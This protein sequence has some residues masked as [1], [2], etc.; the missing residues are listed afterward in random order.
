M[1]HVNHSPTQATTIPP[2]SRGKG[3]GKNDK[4]GLGGPVK[5]GFV[6]IALF[7]GVFGGW[8]ALAP[9]DSAA[10][11]PGV[12]RVDTNRKTVQHLEGGIIKDI[13]VRDGDTVTMGQILI[14]LDDTQA[15]ATLDLLRGRK[16]AA[17]ALEARLVAERDGTR[18]IEFP[19]WLLDDDDPAKADVIAGQTKIFEARRKSLDTQAAILKQ[20]IAQ[21]SE[22]IV[23]LKG[24]IGSENKQLALILEEI[25]DVQTLFDKG[26]AEKPR[27]LAL[28]RLA[29]EIEGN[30]SQNEANIARIKQ[31]IG[32]TRLQI[33]ELKAAMIGEVVEQHREVQSE[34]F[35]LEERM[36]A[37]QDIL[38]RTVIRAPL[39]GTVVALQVYTR[40]GVIS[41][42]A[43]ILDIVPSQDRLVISAQIDPNDIDVV[44][45]GQKAEVRFTAFS[46]RD[47]VPV[48]GIVASVSADR[49]TD[50]TSGKSYFLA[51][52]SLP[53]E[54]LEA[55]ND[56]E[57]V[58][59]MQAE[60]M[61]IT[62]E[63]TLLDY[64]LNPLS[65]SIDRSLRED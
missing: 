41:P 49:L 46:R 24:Q 21:F 36:L 56:A 28:Q 5:A 43:P 12:V 47:T 51:R 23:G 65:R 3:P 54:A 11:A 16:M 7:F 14:E 55:L 13:K 53:D 39:D 57:L 2:P 25:G 26:L 35:D 30:R 63:R 31:S 34:L 22:E 9:L 32:E 20:R 19:Q 61:I 59:G 58:S 1:E 44:H 6:V 10:I 15:R 29:A 37:S 18:A 42:G 33:I 38:K 27:L 48:E 45:I 4:P 17:G 62:G 52:I 8:S 60:V 64:I 50:E 40:E